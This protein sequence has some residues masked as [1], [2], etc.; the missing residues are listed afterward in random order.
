[1]GFEK[2]CIESMLKS[3]VW[4]G[5]LPEDLVSQLCDPFS[6]LAWPLFLLKLSIIRHSTRPN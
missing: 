6:N 5:I 3:S 2:S 4:F 1:M